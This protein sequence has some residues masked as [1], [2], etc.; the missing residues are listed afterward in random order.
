MKKVAL[1]MVVVSALV[2]STIG[3]GKSTKYDTFEAEVIAKAKELQKEHGEI[4][5]D[6]AVAYSDGTSE[7]MI[8]Y[9]YGYGSNYDVIGD[10]ACLYV[11]TDGNTEIEDPLGDLSSLGKE[12]VN[13][14][15]LQAKENYNS[16]IDAKQKIT[17]EQY[18]N[19]EEGYLE[20][21]MPSS[22]E[23]RK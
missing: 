5:L 4:C 6:L 8:I 19:H 16:Y 2:L 7:Y 14:K 1:V 18:K 9:Y 3:C 23:L 17:Y 10:A 11:T 20:S 21:I 22:D 13:V 12:L 15:V